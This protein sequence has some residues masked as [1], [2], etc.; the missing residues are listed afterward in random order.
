[1]DQN[2]LNWI[3]VSRGIAMLMVIYSH[4]FYCSNIVMNYLSPIFLTAFFFI[5]GYLQ[6]DNYNFIHCCP[7]KIL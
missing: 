4:L 2:R 3:D 6:K 5:S 7:E 1:M